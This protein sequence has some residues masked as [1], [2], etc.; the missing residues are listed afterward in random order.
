MRM[1]RFFSQSLGVLCKFLALVSSQLSPFP[2]AIARKTLLLFMCNKFITDTVLVTSA[3]MIPSSART[4][5]PSN[6]S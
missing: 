6:K 2:P 1:V 3:K 5:L 4:A